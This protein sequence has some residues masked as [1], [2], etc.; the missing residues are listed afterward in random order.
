MFPFI[1][2]LATSLI[3]YSSLARE[4]WGRQIVVSGLISQITM[5]VSWLWRLGVLG[6][7]KKAH[8][9][10]HLEACLAWQSSLRARGFAS[11]CR[12]PESKNQPTSIEEQI[13]LEMVNAVVKVALTRVHSSESRKEVCVKVVAMQLNNHSTP[14]RPRSCISNHVVSP[15]F[16][17]IYQS[18]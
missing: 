13:L 3:Y 9:N 10:F 18:R 6:K 5:V 17:Y 14:F 15:S 4:A 7:I 1:L 11:L 16:I 8:E 12:F 2:W